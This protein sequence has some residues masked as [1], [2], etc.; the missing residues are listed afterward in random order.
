LLQQA[1]A[2]NK[3]VVTNAEGEAGRFISVYNQYVKAPGITKKRIYIETMEKI[4]RDMDKIMIDKNAS[5]SGVMPYFPLNEMKEK[6]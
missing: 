2:Y 1:E 3:E 6:K 5:K 4:Y